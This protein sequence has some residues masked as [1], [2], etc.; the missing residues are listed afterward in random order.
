MPDEQLEPIQSSLPSFAENASR[1]PETHWPPVDSLEGIWLNIQPQQIEQTF[2]AIS[3]FWGMSSESVRERYDRLRQAVALSGIPELEQREATLYA[4]HTYDRWEQIRQTIQS[5]IDGR[6]LKWGLVHESAKHTTN[7][8]AEGLREDE[9]AIAFCEA[10]HERSDLSLTDKEI[11]EACAR[12]TF[13]QIF[14]KG[15]FHIYEHTANNEEDD[16]VDLS[17][18]DPVDLEK[19]Q[20]KAAL[21]DP[22][23]EG[24]ML[25]ERSLA[26]R[27]IRKWMLNG[28]HEYDLSDEYDL[29]EDLWLCATKGKWTSEQSALAIMQWGEDLHDTL[30]QAGAFSIDL[31]ALM[32]EEAAEAEENAE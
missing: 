11:R 22:R 32:E 9:Q 18:Q 6:P 31:I 2:N 27:A 30:E 10:V 29:I 26:Y 19:N 4:R 12:L 28:D 25:Q 8:T 14:D 21:G 15:L 17:T 20:I 16:S 1:L 7:L 13:D 3:L 24:D 5:A 23:W